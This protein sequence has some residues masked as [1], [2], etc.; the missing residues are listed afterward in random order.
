MLARAQAWLG[1]TLLHAGTRLVPPRPRSQVRALATYD[2]ATQ[3][4][5]ARGWNAPTVGPNTGA[6]YSLRTLRDRSRAAVRNDGYSKA[7]IDRLV[8]NIVGTGILP[9]SK[10]PDEAFKERLHQLWLDW[11]DEA[12]ADGRVDLYGLQAL[13][14]R[15]WLEAGEMFVRLRRRRPEDGLTVPLQLQL[16]EPELIPHEHNAKNGGNTIRAGIELSPIGERVAYWAWQQRPGDPDL[17]ETGTR[18][19][20]PADQVVHLYEPIRAGQLRGLPQLTQALLKLHDL[21]K[22]DDA[23][24]LRQQIS[25]MFVGFL[26]RPGLA[27]QADVD[28]LTGQAITREGDEAIVGLEPGLF[29]ELAPGED[30]TW[31][32]PPD[33]TGY[34]DFMRA[35]LMAAAVAADVPYEILTGDLREINDRTVRVILQEFRRRVEQRQ[36]HV[37]AFTL[38]RPIWLAF[39]ERA[40]L[41]G[42]LPV[43]RAYWDDPTPWQRVEWIPPAWPYLHPVQDVEQEIRMVR[44]GFKSRAQ[45]VKQRGWDVEA[46]DV[47]IAADKARADRLGLAFDSD[48]S[49]PS[50]GAAAAVP[51]DN[52]DDRR[53][54]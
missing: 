2:G 45:V 4:R 20:I 40:I 33:A 7:A 51:Q 54:Q 28:P 31:S 16:L 30:V 25:N 47:E 41:S 43:P 22:Y 46:I 17:M 15:G 8:S 26:K 13:A 49:R 53:A 37:V 18:V 32:D 34:A 3:T 21:D 36:H 10:A 1:R 50:S 27:E 5:R 6:L 35:Q 9:Q 23:T 44:A 42:A 19:R 29:Q 12:D 11:T 38:N 24:L 52:P 14:V 39:L 48:G